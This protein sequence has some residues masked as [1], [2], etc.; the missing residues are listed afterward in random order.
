MGI[1][2]EWIEYLNERKNNI[3]DFLE[4]EYHV[5]TFKLLQKNSRTFFSNKLQ[6]ENLKE[7]RMACIMDQFTLESYKPECNLLELTPDNWKKEIEEFDPE[8]IFIESA[9]Q[10]KDGMWSRKIAN[11]SPELYRMTSYCQ[12]KEIPIVFWNK[13]DPVYTDTFMPAA[14]CADFVFTTDIDCIKKYKNAL[15]HD[16]VFFLHFAAQPKV[17]NPIEKYERKDKFCFAGAYYHKYPNRTKTFDN[18]SEV[19]LEKKGFDIYDRNYDNPRPEFIFPEKYKSNILGCLNSSKIDVAYKGYNFGVNMNS[20]EQSQTMF[21]RRVFETLASNTVIVGNYS[22]GVKNLFG[23]LTI[24]TNDVKTLKNDLDARC[25]DTEEYRKYRLLGL[26]KVLEQHLYE[27]RLSYVTKKVFGVEIKEV[28]PMISLVAWPSADALPYILKT[29]KQQIYKNKYLY[30]I[31]DFKEIDEPNVR[32][33]DI[34]N[35]KWKKV[36]EIITDGYVGLLNEK[37]HYGENYLLDMALTFRYANVAGVGKSAYY[38]FDGTAFELLNCD[39]AYKYS[40]KIKFDRGIFKREV[41]R[42]ECF[43]ELKCKESIE[44]NNIFAIDEFNF[45][46]NY[47]KVKCSKVDDKMI[48]DQGISIKEIE[49]I[50]EKID[51]D[52]QTD[53]IIKVS[54]NEIEKLCKKSCPINVKSNITNLSWRL[55]SELPKD[56]VQ[57]IYFN[58]FYKTEEYQR[59]GRINYQCCGM[60]D[61]DILGICVFYDHRKRKLEHSFTKFNSLSS[62]KIPDK[63]KFFKLGFRISGTGT[64][65]VKEILLGLEHDTGELSCYLSRSNVLILSN[66]YPSSKV[67]YRNMFVHKRAMSYKEH[68][69]VCDVMR[70]NLYAQNEFSEFEGINIIEG[71]GERLGNVINTSKINKICVHFLDK[72]MWEILKHFKKEIEIFVWIH[73]A[74]I[75]PWWRRKYNYTTEAELNQ[76]KKDSNERQDFW[77][78]VFEEIDEYNIHFIFVSQYFAKEVFED[79]KI[80]L[81]KEKYSIIHNCIDTNMFTYIKKSPE[82]RKKILSIRPYASKIYANDLMVKVIQKL[83]K[84]NFFGELQFLII[85]DGVLFDKTVAPLRKISNVEI[86][87][88]FLRQSEIV[89][90]YHEFGMVL[91]PSRGDTQGVSR[92]EAMSCG[93]VPITNAVGAIPEFVDNESGVIVEAENWEAMADEIKKIY[94]D[95]DCFQRLSENASRRVRHQ[96]ASEFTTSKELFLLKR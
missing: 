8:L 86:R 18:F 13:E 40:S 34:D 72:S 91:I 80:Q 83:S 38:S 31:G 20:I 74:E 21:A 35:T 42:N 89:E 16:N 45:C 9:W 10:G 79:Y 47:S 33:L 62:N 60:G 61:L 67:L 71:K 36:T 28:L 54:K 94:F 14:R 27:D 90:L 64:C 76:A 43:E 11:G 2:E 12:K 50:A 96:T 26:R 58:N 4:T 55:E 93:V 6:A 63:A 87:K 53:N 51:G 84:E 39:A 57:Y 3:Q 95:V 24:C 81:P 56:T 46:E 70:M 17:H 15:G 41:F 66:Q 1:A 73:G 85:G 44:N 82:Q 7:L 88:T 25:S 75:Q 78:E 59:N 49:S 23:D 5:D 22:R 19:F 77:N 68:G 92:D 52:L 30:L 69:V 37:N 32:I 65:E 29:F 48:P